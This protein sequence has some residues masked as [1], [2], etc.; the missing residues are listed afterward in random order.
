MVLIE[1][2]LAAEMDTPT[3]APC[4]TLKDQ[5]LAPKSQGASMSQ[6]AYPSVSILRR[7]QVESRT[8][9]S[10][11]SI[12]KMMSDGRFPKPVSLGARSVGWIENQIDQWLES[13][14][15]RA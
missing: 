9:L 13:R 1:F 12:Y 4:E 15:V 14:T 10:R 3:F 5:G 8:C 6:Q 2:Y 11:S 7:K